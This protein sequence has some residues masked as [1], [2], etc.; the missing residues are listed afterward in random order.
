MLRVL[1]VDDDP[2]VLRSTRRALRTKRP[3][4]Q[5]IIQDGPTEALSVLAREPIDVVVSD[6]EMPLMTGI[7]LFRRM[8]RVHPTVLR[9]IV[10][11]K[12]PEAA[13]VLPAGLVDAWLPKA[14]AS[15]SLAA[16]L[17]D[18]L[19]RRDQTKRNPRLG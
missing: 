1:L 14:S 9:V 3:D 17:E 13:G 12:P 15:E 5:I 4:W 10:S 19:V 18:L 7:D 8:R 6:F 2:A 16:V 11:G